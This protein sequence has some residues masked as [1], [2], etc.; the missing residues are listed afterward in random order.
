MSET[1]FQSYLMGG[2]EC[3][4]HRNFTGKRLDVIA[5]TR[6]DDFA[7]AD[8]E[9]LLSVGMRTARDGVRWHLIEREPFRYDFSSAAKQ[10]RA[11]EKTGIQIIWDLFHYGYPDDLDIFSEDFPVRFARFAEAFIKFLLSEDKRT[12]F[13]CPVNEISFFAWIAGEVG[14]FYPFKK[15]RGD[16]MKRRLVLASVKAIDTIRRLCPEARFV[17]VDPA[18][19]IFPDSR[20]AAHIADAK[21][22]RAAQF[23][24]TDMLAGLTEP[25]IGG[26]ETYLDIVGVNYYSRNQWRQPSGAAV[27]RGAADYRPFSEILLENYQRYNRPILIAETGTEDEARPEWFRYISEQA[28]IARAGGVPVQGICLYP[29][30]NHP[31]WDDDRHCCNGLWDYADEAGNR[32]IYAPLAEEIGRDEGRGMRD[33]G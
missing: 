10:I 24:S 17:Q 7:E 22:F 8:Y 9:R 21:N 5:A 20:R 14:G 28:R 2:F 3:S 15:E 23:H 26:G 12:P 4:T 27:L 16:E 6:H 29:I 11:A 31:G 18:I 1:I 33:E 30:L 25:E 32:E 13:I 19:E